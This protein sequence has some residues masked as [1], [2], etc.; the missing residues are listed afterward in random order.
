MSLHWF[1]EDLIVYNEYLN[2][3]EKVILF[4]IGRK[5][6]LYSNEFIMFA[7]SL[8]ILPK[9]FA[10]NLLSM[11]TDGFLIRFDLSDEIYCV[12]LHS[13]FVDDCYQFRFPGDYEKFIAHLGTYK[14]TNAE[15][16]E[17]RD[18]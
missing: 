1:N 6:C 13:R 15:I 8:D 2:F 10:V 16:L 17:L 3:Q 18:V 14:Y 9:Y 11:Q 5:G 12:R 4:A 7:M